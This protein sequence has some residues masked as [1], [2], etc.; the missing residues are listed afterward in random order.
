MQGM[1]ITQVFFGGVGGEKIGVRRRNRQESQSNNAKKADEKEGFDEVVSAKALPKDAFRK[2]QLQP[3]KPITVW[4]AI[5]EIELSKCTGQKV[6]AIV[7]K[8]I[9]PIASSE[10]SSRRLLAFLSPDR[11][12]AALTLDVSDRPRE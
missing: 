11:S 5:Q 2:I 10:A 12:T 8:R 4:V 1:I 7:M 6:I 3:E 9:T